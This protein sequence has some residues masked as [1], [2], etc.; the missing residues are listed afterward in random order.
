MSCMS[1]GRL[2]GSFLDSSLLI[3]LCFLQCN[4]CLFVVLVMQAGCILGCQLLGLHPLFNKV[5]NADDDK[6]GNDEGDSSIL[7][8]VKKMSRI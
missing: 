5:K 7:Q 1:F 2:F 3:T 6:V 4:T 8:S